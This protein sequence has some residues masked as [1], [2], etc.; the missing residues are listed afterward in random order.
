M[1]SSPP[2]LAILGAGDHGRVVANAAR[3]AGVLS[4]ALFLDDRETLTGATVAGLPVMGTCADLAEIIRRHKI[5]AAIVAI[6][7]A[8]A[9]LRLASLVDAAGVELASVVHPA[10]LVDPGCRIGRGV[11]VDAR[12]C[13]THNA[14]IGDLAIVNPMVS[15]NHDNRIGE[16]A[17]LAAGVVLGGNVTVGRLALLGVGAVVAPGVEIGEGCLV[18][19]GAVCLK[20]TAP[21]TVVL[22]NPARRIRSRR[23]DE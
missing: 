23:E 9:R 21:H 10:A 20:D 4:P 18:A 7:A 5:S 14:E 12:A 13:L 6:G 8:K 19:A 11:F 22:G 2:R 3:L 1:S 15:V 17:H 16:A